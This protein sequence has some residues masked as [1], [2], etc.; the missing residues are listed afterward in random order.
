M[1]INFSQDV[2][3]S[4]WMEIVENMHMIRTLVY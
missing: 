2:W 3:M 4:N 1:A